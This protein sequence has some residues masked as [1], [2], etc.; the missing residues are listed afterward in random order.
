MRQSKFMLICTLQSLL[1]TAHCASISGLAFDIWP[2]DTESCAEP[3][4][5]RCPDD[6]LPSNFCCPRSST[7]LSLDDSTTLVCCPKGRDC[8][9]IR[10]ITCDIQRQN[11]SKDPSSVVKTTKLLEPLSQCGS[12]CCPHGYV[13]DNGSCK[14]D[15]TPSKTASSTS[16][17]TPEPTSTSLPAITTISATP[18]SI[19]SLNESTSED[20]PAIPGVAV[21]A[22]FFP[23]IV[24]GIL[25]SMAFCYWQKRRRNKNSSSPTKI[26]HFH[27]KSDDGAILS[28][29]DPIPSSAQDSVRTDFLRHHGS[30][31]RRENSR[32]VRERA[33][34][35]VRSFF[36]PKLTITIPDSSTMPITPPNQI[37]PRREPSMESIRVY[38]PIRLNEGQALPSRNVNA[39]DSRP[40]TTFSQMMES[41]G[42]QNGH[43]SPF[44]PVGETPRQPTRRY[45]AENTLRPGR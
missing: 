3:N 17:T 10:P 44:Y 28:I 9:T 36:A 18:L 2:R 35:R 6:K 22:G 14:V 8:T 41:V 7:C 37:Y 15:T 26:N 4:L 34:T 29:S 38:S 23:G 16:T 5:S 12:G 25:I 43:G 13:C 24:A 45:Q 11:V 21:A 31:E 39:R 1:I 19:P 30:L 40:P 20:C 27:H 42:F 32:S 33:S